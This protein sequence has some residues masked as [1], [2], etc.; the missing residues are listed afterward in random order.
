M[1][2][3]GTIRKKTCF[4]VGAKV[5]FG[6]LYLWPQQHPFDVTGQ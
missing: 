3:D 5:G 2:R 6:L 4:F 1:P